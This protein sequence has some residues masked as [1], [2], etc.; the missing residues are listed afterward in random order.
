MKVLFLDIDGVLN[1]ARSCIANHGYP[2]SFDEHN[3]PMFDT[4]AVSLIRGLCAKGDVSVVV[5]SA[6]R[7]LHDWDAIGRGLDLPTIGNT[8]QLVG[9]RG[10]EIAA[11]L[12][13]H[14]EVEQYAIVDDDDDMLAEQRPFFVKTN[15]MD[16]LMFAD[17]EK[18]C[19]IFGVSVYDCA[20][21]RVR[22]GNTTKLD[23]EGAF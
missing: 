20:P 5:S 19:G 6:W 3:M 11:W 17:F 2:H 13:E 15:G 14:P 9:E 10:K 1:S 7:I 4:I 18:L 8:P 12:A 22:I 21:N 23:W 16:G